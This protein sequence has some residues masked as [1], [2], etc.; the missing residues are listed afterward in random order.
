[1]LRRIL[2]LLAMLGEAAPQSLRFR[3]KGERF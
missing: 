1:M 2:A 3:V